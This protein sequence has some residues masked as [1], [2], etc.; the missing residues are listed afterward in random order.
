MPEW[1]PPNEHKFYCYN[2]RKG[3]KHCCAL[4]IH[5]NIVH[6]YGSIG[7]ACI[8]C[9][10]IYKS[11][12]CRNIH[13]MEEHN[14]NEPFLDFNSTVQDLYFLLFML[15]LKKKQFRDQEYRLLFATIKF[16]NTPHLFCKY[17]KSLC[18]KHFKL[19]LGGKSEDVKHVNDM[20]NQKAECSVP[21]LFPEF[22][23]EETSNTNDGGII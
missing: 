9:K 23:T 5:Q 18:R 1:Y 13:I 20:L 21:S 19:C 10:A 4:I 15:A 17:C 14:G 6:H 3:F 22:L 8:T 2:C 16:T 12:A 11:K 7:F